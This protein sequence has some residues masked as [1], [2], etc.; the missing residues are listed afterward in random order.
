MVCTPGFIWG[1]IR[2]EAYKGRATGERSMFPERK[3]MRVSC[4]EC[5][6]LVVA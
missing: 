5:R 2:E 4:S 1:Q 6:A 3:E